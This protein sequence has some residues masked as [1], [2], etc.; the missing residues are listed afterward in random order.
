MADAD[1]IPLIDIP[2]LSYVDPPAPGTEPVGKTIKRMV[3]VIGTGRPAPERP[4]VDIAGAFDRG[5]RNDADLAMPVEPVHGARNPIGR[6]AKAPNKG[7]SYRPAGRP[8]GAEDLQGLFATGL[9]LLL[10]FAVG[11]WA[12]PTADEALAISAPL[13]NIVARRIDL[14]AKLGKDASDTIALAVALLSY[15]A[16]VGPIAAERVRDNV[17]NRRRRERVVAPNGPSAATG[18]GSV[19]SWEDAGP[20]R[21]AESGP[22]YDPFDALAKAR[23]N[24]LGILDRDLGLAERGNPAV[25]DNR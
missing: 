23:N 9:I 19:A 18:E 1:D 4:T 8:P 5:A 16:R 21:S 3:D 22:S 2:E 10:V 17:A 7:A 11:D 20:T 13:A 15:L 12:Q 6:G 24:G 14:A 25:G